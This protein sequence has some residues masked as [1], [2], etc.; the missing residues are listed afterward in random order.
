MRAKNRRENELF[1][2]GDQRRCLKGNDIWSDSWTG[3][4]AKCGETQ[5]RGEGR[6]GGA[7]LSGLWSTVPSILKP[8]QRLFHVLLLRLWEGRLAPASNHSGTARMMKSGVNRKPGIRETYKDESPC[9]SGHLALYLVL[10]RSNKKKTRLRRRNF[11]S[12]INYCNKK[13]FDLRA[14]SESKFNGK[15]LFHTIFLLS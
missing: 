13:Y 1:Q 15:G 11:V 7:F 5:R 4:G 6:Y 9:H 8:F 14:Y 12:R 3:Q 2:L 10:K